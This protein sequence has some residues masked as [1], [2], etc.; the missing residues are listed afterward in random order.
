[1]KKRP[2]AALPRD[3]EAARR[4]FEDWRRTRTR[5]GPLPDSLWALAAELAARHGCFRTARTLG[6]DSS[7]L[8]RI[9]RAPSSKLSRKAPQRRCG[10]TDPTF[11][12]LPRC[13]PDGASSCLLEFEGASGS[14][15]RIRLQGAALEDVARF[16]RQIWCASER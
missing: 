14:R 13:D 10:A 8:K 11:I 2:T 6:L 1:M 9:A 7:K 5:V 16:A 3:L 4:R 12:E 15:L